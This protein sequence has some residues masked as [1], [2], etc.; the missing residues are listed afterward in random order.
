[1]GLVDAYSEVTATVDGIS[2][3]EQLDA[4]VH[5]LVQAYELKHAAY[6]MPSLPDQ[7]Q[8][9]PLS[10]ITYP[11]EWVRRYFEADYLAVDPVVSESFANLLPLDWGTLDK[12]APRVKQLFGES[13]EFG[14]GRQGITFPIRGPKG[15]SALFSVTSDL[16]DAEWIDAKKIYIRDLQILAHT[17]HA[18]AMVIGGATRPDYPAKLT[19]REREC[20]TWCAL[21]KTSEDIATI[22]GISEGVVRI[23]LQSAQH[24][25][26]CL[27]RTHT[28]AKAI[29]YK[30]IFPNI[31]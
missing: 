28:V 25:L 17:I 13:R 30:L 15:E 20:L 8:A 10:I 21:G 26:N 24:K 31:R 16:P 27:N 18:K 1:M 7:E 3:L 4:F 9:R 11:P 12:R 29:A 14:I 19:P 23:H 2:T 6:Y 5:R 22:L